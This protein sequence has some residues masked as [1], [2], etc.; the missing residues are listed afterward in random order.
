MV[1]LILHYRR[2]ARLA[3]DVLWGAVEADPRTAAVPVRQASGGAGLAA[4]VAASLQ[5]GRRPVVGWSFY[6]ASFAE[7]AAELQAVRS[8]APGALHLAGGPHASAAAEEVLRA[9]FDLVAVGEGEETLPALLARLAA[10]EDG[11]A[12]PGLAW[13]ED[14]AVRSSGRAPPVDLEAF[15]PCAPGAGRIGPIEITRG[16]VW[17]CR[18]CQTPFQFKA[19]FRHRSLESV[20]RWVA[21]HARLEARD[22]RFLTPSALSW[23]S[24]DGACDEAAVEALLATAREAAGPDRRLFLGS[25]PSELRPEHVSVRALAAIRRRC[26]NRT[27]IVGAQSGSAR[28]LEAMGRGHG[29]EEVRRAVAL[30]VEAGFVPSVDSGVRASRGG[31]A[32]PPGL[33]GAGAGA[34]RPRGAHPRPRLHAAPRHAVGA[35]AG[36]CHR[37]RHRGAAGAAGLPRGRP[38]PVEAAGAAG[39]PPGLTPKRA[40]GGLTTVN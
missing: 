30:A 14:G 26:D 38:R 34:G 13:L 37:P 33:A 5:D 32:R 11:R 7:A 12:G 36:G 10:G 28:L 22:I 3:L 1:E 19:R 16:C 25:F 31:G 39:R 15:P 35:R 29:V 4:A 8:A 2:T 27:V 24:A 18:F 40:R 17:G 21:H 9:G 23:G 6:T 20:R